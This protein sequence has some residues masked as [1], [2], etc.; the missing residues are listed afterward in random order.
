MD[1]S[2][3]IIA[4]DNLLEDLGLSKVGDRLSLRGFC[5][6]EVE[7]VHEKEAEHTREQKRSYLE[8]FFL[9]KKVKKPP[10]QSSS[11]SD[12]SEK[13]KSKKIQIGW[14]HF[15]EKEHKFVLV[16]LAKG[17]GSRMIDMPL[18]SN[19]WDVMKAA[20]ELFFPDGESLY[21]NMEDMEFDLANFKD[22]AI[23]SSIRTQK[24]K[25]PFTLQSYI[26]THKAKTVRIY[27]R[28]KVMEMTT[29][30]T[31]NG[32]DDNSSSL[33]GC[34]EEKRSILTEQN[35]AY[36]ESLKID[37]AKKQTREDARKEKLK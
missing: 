24:G 17:G 11:P 1:I 12:I 30:A 36:E 23:H 32:C 3:I 18:S 2:A 26:H 10:L 19:R 31:E 25:V 22:E 14:K 34:T 29:D 5:T 6:K 27:I 37:R 13:S 35:Q 15:S 16:P 33:I 21:G 4:S 28:S 9:R 7:R 20:K 8:A